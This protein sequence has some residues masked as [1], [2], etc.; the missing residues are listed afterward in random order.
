M[1]RR[2]HSRTPFQ[3]QFNLCFASILPQ[4]DLFL[5]S[6]ILILTPAQPAISNHGQ[7]TAIN[8]P[9]GRVRFQIRFRILKN[10]SGGSDSASGS[11]ESSSDCSGS[12]SGRVLAFLYRLQTSTHTYLFQLQ[13]NSMYQRRRQRNINRTCDLEGVKEWGEEVQI[14]PNRC[15]CWNN[16]ITID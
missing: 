8:K 5:T 12:Y 10:G 9:L 13:S 16:T 14:L 2:A 7:E 6:F 11:W 15:F 4:F 1:V 3:P